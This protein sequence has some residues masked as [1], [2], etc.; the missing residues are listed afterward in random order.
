[1]WSAFIIKSWFRYVVDHWE[2]ISSEAALESNTSGQPSDQ[3]RSVSM[4]IQTTL[5]H[6]TATKR[7]KRPPIFLAQKALMESQGRKGAWRPPRTTNQLISTAKFNWPD[8]IQFFERNWSMK[9]NQL[10]QS[11]WFVPVFWATSPFKWH[12]PN[13]RLIFIHLLRVFSQGK[14][15]LCLL[16]YLLSSHA[17]AP[18]YFN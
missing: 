7:E 5:W 4:Q 17:L 6:F 12:C 3:M 18:F 2:S 9:W 15:P 11:K 1:M 16:K 10:K 8:S 14:K 13:R